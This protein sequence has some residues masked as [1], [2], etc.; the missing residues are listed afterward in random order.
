MIS[1]TVFIRK[2]KHADVELQFVLISGEHSCSVCSHWFVFMTMNGQTGPDWW[3]CCSYGSY[4][5][6]VDSGLSWFCFG[7][8]EGTSVGL[9]RKVLRGLQ[10]WILRDFC[11]DSSRAGHKTHLRHL[12]PRHDHEGAAASSWSSWPCVYLCVSV[13]VCSYFS[14]IVSWIDFK[15]N[16]DGPFFFS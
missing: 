15:T 10:W 4:L 2:W 7:S 13:C 5:L 1:W 14:Q 3:S 11:S 6:H 16:P 9:V 12:T 8:P